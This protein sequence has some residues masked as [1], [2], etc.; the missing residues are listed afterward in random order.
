MNNLL[1]TTAA[2]LALIAGAGT[3]HAQVWLA[4]APV[5]TRT[6][7]PAAPPVLTSA[8]RTTIYRTIVPRGRG[9]PPI[10]HE[11]IVTETIPAVPAVRE[12][13]VTRPAAPDYAY[14]PFTDYAYAPGARVTDYVVGSRVPETVTLRP[15]PAPV[16][17]DVPAVRPYRYM[18]INGRLLLVD[19]VTSTVVAELN[20][21]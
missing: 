18:V 14:N 5:E 21:Y 19:P 15:L 17:A 12:R 16:I 9:R 8:Q 10:V 1:R 3:A 4:P 7:V 2:T 13:V 20:Q 11:R 6:I